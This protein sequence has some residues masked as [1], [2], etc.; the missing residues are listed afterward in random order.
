[1]KRLI[2][3]DLIEWKN[4]IQRKPLILKGVRQIGKTYILNKFDADHFDNVHYVNFENNHQAATA[5]KMDFNPTRI[6]KELSFLLQKPIDKTK[7]LVIFDEIQ[8]CPPALTSKS[9]RWFRPAISV[10]GNC[11]W[12]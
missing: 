12:N 4:K 7:D 8:A 3:S 10:Q 6:L 2:S 1:M 11:S 5:F 9:P